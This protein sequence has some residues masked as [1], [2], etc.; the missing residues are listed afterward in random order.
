[1]D[2]IKYTSSQFIIA[3]LGKLHAK[4]ENKLLNRFCINGQYVCQ[5]GRKG[6]NLDLSDHENLPL[7]RFN[8]IHI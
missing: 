4:I 6:E 1:M 3:L 7:E 8:Q 5:N 2:S